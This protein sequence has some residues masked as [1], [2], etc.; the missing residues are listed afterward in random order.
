[1][2]N[3]RLLKKLQWRIAV[4]AIGPSTL[5]NQGASGVNEVA[6]SFLAG[7]KIRRFASSNEAAFRRKLDTAT[8]AGQ[9]SFPAGAQHWGTA[10]KAI[11]VFLRDCLY[12]ADLSSAYNIARIRPWLELP[13]DSFAARGLRNDGARLPRWRGVKHLDD[14]TNLEYQAAARSIA[15]KLPGNVCRVDLDLCY[16]RM[17]QVTVS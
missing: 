4:L 7:L 3:P 1:M 17:D 13:L 9:V 8:E 5:R 2:R 12:S 15:Q 6:R 11:N 10:R 16:W 14:S